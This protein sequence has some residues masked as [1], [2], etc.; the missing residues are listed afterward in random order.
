MFPALVLLVFSAIG[1]QGY[2]CSGLSV[3][4][5]VGVHA[6]CSVPEGLNDT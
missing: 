1:G 4:R 5:A 6:S 3:F 2:R